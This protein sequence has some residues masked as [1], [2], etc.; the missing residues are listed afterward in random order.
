MTQFLRW[1]ER[2]H[3]SVKLLIVLT[4]AFTV[5]PVVS[6]SK[7]AATAWDALLDRATVAKD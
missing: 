7:R 1:G 4:L 6:F 5:G 2:Q 3:W